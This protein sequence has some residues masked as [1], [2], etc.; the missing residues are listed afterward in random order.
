MV[1]GIYVV[2]AAIEP[3]GGEGVRGRHGNNG[4]DVR[5]REESG[6]HNSAHGVAH[7][8]YGGPL[9]VEGE[10]IVDRACRIRGLCVDGGAMKGR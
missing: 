8:N 5:V 6:S 3:Y 7:D 2:Y 4:G 9:R 1:A 10:D